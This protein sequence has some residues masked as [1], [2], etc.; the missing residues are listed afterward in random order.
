MKAMSYL[1]KEAYYKRM[2][3]KCRALRRKLR[4]LVGI[5]AKNTIEDSLQDCPLINQGLVGDCKIYDTVLNKSELKTC[6]A[7]I[8]AY[9]RKTIGRETF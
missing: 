8:Y 5:V 3:A 4:H 2:N 7:C 6:K 9:L 1:M